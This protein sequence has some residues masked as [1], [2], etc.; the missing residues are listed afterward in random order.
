V[1]SP[2]YTSKDQQHQHQHQ[3]QSGIYA[4][5]NDNG[6][7]KRER[8][9]EENQH[10]HQNQGQQ[11]LD[12]F[13]VVNMNTNKASGGGGGG[14]SKDTTTSSCQSH[15][16]DVS[17]DSSTDPYL[18]EA[19]QNY[20]LPPFFRVKGESE[21]AFYVQAPLA[22][23]PNTFQVFAHPDSLIGLSHEIRSKYG[24]R[25][26]DEGT[27]LKFKPSLTRCV[28]LKRGFWN[29]LP[30]TKVLLQP[31]TGRRH[32]LRLHMAI[33]GH[34]I[35][36]DVTYEQGSG[37]QHP[38]KQ[39]QLERKTCNRMCLHAHKLTIPLS[40]ESSKPKVF[41]AADPFVGVI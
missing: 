19:G 18:N 29:G 35:L 1:E 17:Y 30:V 4:S 15:A 27:E 12:D 14:K 16:G 31:R 10:Q 26:T 33:T 2:S 9:Y 11:Q 7:K 13:G 36:G 38:P 24:R 28:V 5:D 3:H 22:E 23:D 34:A 20:K 6:R 41:I 37:S 32:Q 39:K 8:E 25:T 40:K 21:D